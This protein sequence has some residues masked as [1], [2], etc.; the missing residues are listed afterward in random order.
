MQLARLE[1]RVQQDEGFRAEP[2]LCSMGVPTIGFGTTQIYGRRVTLDDEPISFRQ[3]SIVF[4]SDLFAAMVDAEALV[5]SFHELCPI[6]QEV[7]VNMVYNLGAPRFSQFV[8]FISTLAVHNY[9]KASEE[10][11]NSRW[12]GQVGSRAKRLTGEMLHGIIA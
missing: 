12:Y 8:R 9:V 5:P 2:Y 7:I 1:R 10:M 6:R 3:A 11:L 4:R